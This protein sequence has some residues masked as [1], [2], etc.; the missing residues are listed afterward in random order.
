[1][2]D[3]QLFTLAEK[4]LL[5]KPE[6]L[7]AQALRMLRDPKSRALVE[8]FGMQWLTL[9]NLENFNP[10]PKL[11]PNWD[12]Q[13]RQAMYRE[14][15]LF[16]EAIIRE[17]RSVLDLLDARFTFVNERLAKHYGIPGVQGEE[18]RRVSLEGTPRQGVLTHAS[19][20]CIT[21]NPTRT[22]PVKRGK[23]VM[24]QILG[25]PPP[26][27]LP[28][29]PPLDD[30]NQKLTGT[31][32]QR[33][34]QHRQNPMCASC[35]EQMDAIGFGL[36]NFD[37]IGAWRTRDGDAEIDASG[38]LPDGSR[39]R[40]PLE[41]IA[42]L[43]KDRDSFV[44]HFVG[45]LLTFAL[46]RGLEYFDRCAVDGIAAASARKGYRFS[47]IVTEIV[48]SEPFRMRRGDGGM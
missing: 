19:I 16:F 8:N 18:F 40:G 13:L 41:L 6:V 38:T 42:V 35:H 28:D 2:P 12:E 5:K 4:G 22:S 33:M 25:T 14:T 32:R 39:F 11:F 37:A 9:R 10:D 21:S 46:G 24:E 26:P 45:Q 7:E 15:E 43:K 17:D 3:D 23:W 30:P 31:L 47:A 20:L 36:E 44:R 29:V 1:M 48:K 34:E 27:P